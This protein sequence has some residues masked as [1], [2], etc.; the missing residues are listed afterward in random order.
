V[1]NENIRPELSAKIH[2]LR[3]RILENQRLGRAASYGLK[4]EEI[5]EGLELC[6][7]LFG[8][9]APRKEKAR[10]ASNLESAKPLDLNSLLP[11]LT[12]R[13]DL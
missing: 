2:D 7:N 10:V 1:S 3:H 13:K 8:S 12:V 5:R 4:P 6:R 9:G 11:G